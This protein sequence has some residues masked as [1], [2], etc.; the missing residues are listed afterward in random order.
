M[1]SLIN[2]PIYI[3]Y[4]FAGNYYVVD[5]PDVSFNKLDLPYE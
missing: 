3:C 5:A 1:G 4:L 2:K